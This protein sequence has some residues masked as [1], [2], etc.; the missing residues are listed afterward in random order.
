MDQ[1]AVIE[2]RDGG[3]ARPH[4]D[5]GG[6]EINFIIDEGGQPW[7]IGGN[8]N[9]G[10]FQPTPCET[11]HQSADSA[12]CRRDDVHGNAQSVA[13]HA[14]WV[15]NAPC[16]VNGIADGNAVDQ[17]TFAGFGGGMSLRQDLAHIG[18]AD[19]MT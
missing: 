17:F 18:I 3:G 9:V 6:A 16:A 7:G 2:N 14:T 15:T 8:N 10:D 13:I 5:D 1:M 12:R 11:G 4:V 19:F